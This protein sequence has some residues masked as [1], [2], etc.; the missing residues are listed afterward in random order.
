[1]K[2]TPMQRQMR[3]ADKGLITVTWP[4]LSGERYTAK[5]GH[6]WMVSLNGNVRQALGNC[7]LY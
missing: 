5:L 6:L 3:I 1:M 7:A 4:S 2:A